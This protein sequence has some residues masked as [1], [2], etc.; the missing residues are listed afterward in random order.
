MANLHA[1]AA[2]S[3]CL[4]AFT[5][6]N[7]CR[8]VAAVDSS[9]TLWSTVLPNVVLPETLRQ[10]VSPVEDSQISTR[11]AKALSRGAVF[12]SM[13]AEFCD[14]ADLVCEENVK[15]SSYGLDAE[16]A[17]P[18]ASSIKTINDFQFDFFLEQNLVVGG[19]MHLSE[20]LHDPI[21]TRAFLPKV[22]A[23]SLPP[24]TTANLP[25]LRQTFNIADKTSMSTMM[26]TAAYLCE[27]PALP[28]EDKDCPATLT[29][30]AQFVVSQ[31]GP[32]VQALSTT[33]APAH[34]PTHQSPVQIESVTKRSLAEGDHIIICHSIMFPSA[35]YYC[36]HVT[37]TKVVQASLRAS[38]S[39]I[40]NAVGICH[41]DTS[42]WASE[43]PAF[44]ALNIPRGAEA[45]HWSTENDVVWVSAGTQ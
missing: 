12:P 37:G 35:L 16:A 43:H 29:A 30:M 25:K 28:G 41:L 38:D 5:L 44:T 32:E 27:N 24:L 26:G 19:E 42:L 15:I 10:S 40:I 13:S 14:A 11:F 4:S 33:G 1:A 20:N 18:R 21:P 2:L 45:C 3:L 36:H 34:T 31:L 9:V 7:L 8:F 39:S 6:M 23:D 22:V 17:A